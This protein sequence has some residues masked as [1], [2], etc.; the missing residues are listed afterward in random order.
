MPEATIYLDYESKRLLEEAS[1]QL[2][3]SQSELVRRAL[4]EYLKNVKVDKKLLVISRVQ[5]LKREIK[6]LRWVIYEL[7]GVQKWSYNIRRLREQAPHHVPEV[8]YNK[9]M[10]LEEELKRTLQEY[11]EMLELEEEAESCED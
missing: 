9:I 7:S 1:R 10:R 11:I 8:I 6:H 3:V 2:K 5:Q 4:Q